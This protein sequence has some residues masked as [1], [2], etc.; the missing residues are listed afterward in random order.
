MYAVRT[1]RERQGGA[2]H[3]LAEQTTPKEKTESQAETVNAPT[4]AS[5]LGDPGGS[6]TAILGIAGD[7]VCMASTTLIRSTC[8]PCVGDERVQWRLPGWESAS[9]EVSAVY[10]WGSG[11]HPLNVPEAW[12]RR[13]SVIV[14]WTHALMHVAA[15]NLAAKVEF[16]F[17]ARGRDLT[18]FAS[19]FQMCE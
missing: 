5:R 14:C 7:G 13:C 6:A 11:A 19:D 2:G 18:T 9:G 12:P 10:I 1:V 4:L 8:R 17:G 16:A 3:E 15:A